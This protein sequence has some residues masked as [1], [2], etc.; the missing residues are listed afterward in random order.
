ME[1][2]ADSVIKQGLSVRDAEARARSM[3]RALLQDEQARIVPSSSSDLATRQVEDRLARLLGT[4]VRLADRRGKGR[5]QFY[6]SSTNWMRSWN[7]LNSYE[8]RAT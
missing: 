4:K 6:H 5:I 8:H 1:K 2:L 7:A 3:K